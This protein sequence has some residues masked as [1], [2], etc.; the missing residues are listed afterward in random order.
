MSTRYLTIEDISNRLFITV[1][2]AYNRLSTNKKMP[3]S[4]KIGKKILFPENKFEEWM[5]KQVE[6]NDEIALKKI[7]I[8]RI[9]R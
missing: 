2:T 3:P 7:T 4:I 1:G 8:A 5:E 6:S 9:K